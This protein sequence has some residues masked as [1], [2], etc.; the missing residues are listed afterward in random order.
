MIDEFPNH[1]E[2]THSE[3]E[4]TIATGDAGE[5]NSESS[6]SVDGDVLLPAEDSVE[7]ANEVEEVEEVEEPEIGRAHV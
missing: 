7:D 2:S 5:A 1:D 6:D 4:E 3:G